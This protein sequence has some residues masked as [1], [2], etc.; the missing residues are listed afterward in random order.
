MMPT[1]ASEPP[2]DADA[3]RARLAALARA[4]VFAGAR[5]PRAIPPDDIEC[6]FLDTPVTGTT[7]KFD[8]TGDD[9]ARLRVKYGRTG[10]IHAEVATTHLL[11]ALGFGADDVSMARRVR[12][13][14][15]PRWP[16]LARQATERLHL[17]KFLRDRIDYD[18]YTDFEWVSVEWRG[19]H[20]EL[21]FGDQEG[22][23]W[24][25]LSAIDPAAGGATRAEVDAFRLMAVFLNHWDNKAT[26]QALVCPS[27]RG[28]ADETPA[29][30]HPLA[31][32]QDV[33][34]TFGPKKVDLQAWSDSPVWADASSCTLG[35]KHLPY[36]GSTFQDVTVSEEG[37]RLLAVRL[38]QLT[39]P[40]LTALFT[41][42]RFEDVD[43]WV[44][45]FERRVG[46]IASRPPCPST[47]S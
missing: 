16:M 37:R 3:T 38:Q 12:C 13:Y 47:E 26:N 1:L 40:Q 44:A 27:P 46:T 25:E 18:R 10:E 41:N 5:A 31:L 33:G 28:A 34:S 20:D 45:A 14:G 29:C 39:T 22:W 35:M 42:A 36:N 24:Y 43:R 15:C 19:R 21:E 9:G 32:I 6:R 2:V 17:G 23:S 4:A 11:S 30:D 7:A 8:C